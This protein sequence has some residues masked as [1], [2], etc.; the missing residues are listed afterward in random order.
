MVLK[1]CNEI[2][3]GKFV[4]DN[5][6]RGNNIGFDIKILDAAA[7]RFIV[8]RMGAFTAVS[9]LSTRGRFTRKT[10]VLGKAYPGNRHKQNDNEQGRKYFFKGNHA[11]SKCEGKL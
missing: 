4:L 7:F 3:S 1:K 10:Y 9:A 11:K 5:M 2:V 8:Y 6:M